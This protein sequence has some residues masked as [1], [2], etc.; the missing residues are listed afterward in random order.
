MFGFRK[1]KE[2]HKGKKMKNNCKNQILKYISF[3]D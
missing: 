2:K 3:T 1:Y